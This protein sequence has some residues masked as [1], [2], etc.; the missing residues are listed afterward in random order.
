ME[1][2]AAAP[3]LT[4][5]V[6]ATGMHVSPEFGL[7]YQEIEADGFRIDR[8]VEMLL[9]SDS[10]T[11]VAKSM[12][13]GVMGCADAF[14]EL[15]PDIIVVLGDRFEIL[16]AVAAALVVKVPVA[17]L[18]GGEATEGAIDESIRHAITKM[19]HV[20]FVAANEYRQRVIQMGEH[21]DR[22]FLV[23][24]LGIDNIHRLQLLGRTQLQTALGFPLGKRNLLVTFHPAT[25]DETDSSEQLAELLIALAELEETHLIFTMPNA[26]EGGR[27]LTTMVEDFCKQHAQARSYKS[28]GQLLYLS[29]MLH[30]DA[31][32]GNS[33]SGIIEAPA[34]HKGTVNIG[35]RQRGRL[36]A[37][38]VVDCEPERQSI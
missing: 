17:H 38:S 12:G 11:G 32:V 13:M 27:K 37:A 7:T 15:Q 18:H 2:I 20:H 4:L 19:S 31:V 34:L 14:A 26:D 35:D 24:A 5:Q 23:G 30:V 9:S 3:D 29:C 28:L 6:I 10:A 21:P 1:G 22:V 16:A 36:R 25:L 33:S 8:K